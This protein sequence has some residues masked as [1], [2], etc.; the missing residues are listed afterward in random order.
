MTDLRDHVAAL[1]RPQ[2]LIR[3]A[4]L[5]LA[6]YSRSRDLCRLMRV[7]TAPSPARAVAKLI[8]AEG[9]METTRRQ[10]DVSYSVGRHVELLIALMGELRLMARAADAP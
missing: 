3:A 10:G 4:R 5:G 9:E 2:L 6:D 8:D 7:A 1:R